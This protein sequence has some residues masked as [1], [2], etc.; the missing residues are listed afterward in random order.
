MLR[1]Y[2]KLV[3]AGT[4]LHRNNYLGVHNRPFEGE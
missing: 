3:E 2:L 1:V 4:S